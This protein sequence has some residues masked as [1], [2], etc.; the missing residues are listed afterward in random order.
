M[1]VFFKLVSVFKRKQKVYTLL[2]LVATV[3]AGLLE[4]FSIGLFFPVFQTMGSRDAFM[5]SD[6]MQRETVQKALDFFHVSN[7]TDFLITLFAGIIIVFIVK[8]AYMVVFNIFKQRYTLNLQ[9]ELSIRLFRFYLY[10]DYE[11]FFNK[12]TAEIQRD[13]HITPNNAISSYFISILNIINQVLVIVFVLGGFFL[14]Q[15]VTSAA[16]ITGTIIV[17]AFIYVLIAGTI[18]D[19]TGKIARESNKRILQWCSQCFGAIAEVK[20]NGKESYFLTKYRRIYDY[21]IRAI[22]KKNIV[23]SLPKMILET[24]AMVGICVVCLIYLK[25]GRDL[26]DL[27]TALG[28]YLV[29]LMKLL[30]A[31][32]TVFGYYISAKHAQPF[33]E[34]MFENENKLDNRDRGPRTEERIQVTQGV[35]FDDIVYSYP[36]APDK[37][38]LKNVSL[39]ISANAFIGIVG[40]S[41]SGKSTLVAL[42]VG[43]LPVRK[44]SIKIDGKSLYDD[45]NME[46]WQNNIG[47]IPQEIKLL[48]DTIL[49]NVAYGEDKPDAEKAKKALKM[50]QLSEFIESLSHGLETQVGQNGA[51]LSGGQKQRIGIARA[52]YRDAEVL[53]LDEATSSLDHE[54]AEQ[55]TQN[56]INLKHKLTI[57]SI[58]H[59]IETLA[60]CD[61]VYEMQAGRLTPI[62][63]K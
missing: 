33:V 4:F 63:V 62:E 7:Y 34:A 19:R 52:L 45:N 48:D 21:F 58:S 24:V 30:P 40:R 15:D 3:V 10:S 51:M 55:F 18:G 2:A 38:V 39:D 44:G 53:I 12:N 9:K 36:S 43:L 56:I 14:F 28:Y 50:A 49:A 46:K 23:N 13:I 20:V 41:G 54:T 25:T 5:Q 16:V 26:G 6:F 17:L 42:L 8:N 59:K 1:N 61:Q 22:R 11:S 35:A 31:V 37:D 47:Y 60:E 29:A 57:I 27:V 32:T